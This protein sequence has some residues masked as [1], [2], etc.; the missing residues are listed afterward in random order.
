[1]PGGG[2]DPEGSGT[3]VAIRA[4]LG[5]AGLEPC[6]VGH[7]NAHGAAT[8]ASDLAEARALHRVF[9]H[10]A[11]VPVTAV[12]GYFG[13]IVSGGS[14][15]ELIGR[16]PGANRGLIPPTLN[17]EEPDP[18][19]GLDV[20]QGAPRPTQ[21]LTFVKT[22]LTRHGQAAALLVRGNPEATTDATPRPT[23]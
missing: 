18:E 8:I 19:C 3:E 16:R 20:V 12:K 11:S 1:T 17:C 7:I 9:G 22:S 6:A 23:A 5:D 2:L 13:N 15:V 10:G 14:V 21:N 4:A